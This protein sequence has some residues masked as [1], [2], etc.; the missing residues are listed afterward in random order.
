MPG[1]DQL[2]QGTKSLVA[3]PYVPFAADSVLIVEDADL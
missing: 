1:S 2:E 3:G